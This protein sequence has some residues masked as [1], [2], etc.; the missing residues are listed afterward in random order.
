MPSAIELQQVTK[1]F[2]RPSE[3]PTAY[4]TLREKLLGGQGSQQEGFLAVKDVSLEIETGEWV[5]LVGSNGSGKTTLLKL[6]AGLYHPTR[7]RI[8]V[9]GEVSLLAGLGIGMLDELSV[10]ENVI[11][12]GTIYGLARA[13]LR[14]KLD[15]ILQWAELE[16]FSSARL[17]TLSSGMRTRLAFSTAKHIDK[18]I[19][20]FDEALT[21][22]DKHFRLKCLDV[23]KERKT[24]GRTFVIASHDLSFLRT[25]CTKALW[26]EHG[27]A[28]VFGEAEQVLKDYALSEGA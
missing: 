13:E 20:L 25:F 10:R 9:R 28:L 24:R 4:G 26:L 11:L 12:Y 15:E 27:K 2:A 18:P 3:L 1:A 8:Y 6:I 14:Q 17:K 7:G 22:G 19:C 21:A 5:G 16:E 23:F